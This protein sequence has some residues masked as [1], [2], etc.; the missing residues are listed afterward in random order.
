MY[1]PKCG[2]QINA[3]VRFCNKCGCE[4]PM[5]KRY[6]KTSENFNSL[7]NF[8][9]SFP[10]KT[11]Q[12]VVIVSGI[13]TGPYGIIAGILGFLI[14]NQTDSPF[15]KKL[16]KISGFIWIIWI[17]IIASYIV[18]TTHYGKGYIK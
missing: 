7:L 13:L 11:W 17:I 8:L 10:Q 4:M 1:C 15:A 6:E 12:T 5:E 2:N 18:L 16:L 3:G 14:W 9:R